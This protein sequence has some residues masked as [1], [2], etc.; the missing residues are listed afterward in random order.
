MCGRF[1]LQAS[2]QQVKALFA[3]EDNPNFPPRLNIAPTEPIA[4]VVREGGRNHFR[5]MRWGFLPAWVKDPKDFPLII[6]ARAET[7]EEKPAY[8]TAIRHRRALVPADAFYEWLREGKSK[9]P[10][11]I[12]RADGSLFAM[13][14]LWETYADKNGS[15]IDTAA[16][17]TTPPNAV[18]AALHNRMPAIIE[19]DQF[20]L[21]LDHSVAHDAALRLLKPAAGEWRT[22]PV[23]PRT[24]RPE[25]TTKSSGEKQRTKKQVPPSSQGELF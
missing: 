6:N 24:P 12:E 19:P 23:D 10:Y 1:A 13:A 3:Y 8:R 25:R 16:I 21:W 11:R 9:T 17:I 22:E 18:A 5:L 14:A 20:D 2:P 4:L 7:L 15:E